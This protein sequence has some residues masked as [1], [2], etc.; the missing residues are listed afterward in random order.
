M[1]N[2]SP[3][4]PS[5]LHQ[6]ELMQRCLLGKQGSDEETLLSAATMQLLPAQHY[7]GRADEGLLPSGQGTLWCSHP[8]CVLSWHKQT[9]DKYRKR[10]LT[11]CLQM[12]E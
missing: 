6:G 5:F 10:S 2:N 12:C 9:R 11:L 7:T 1:N 3:P 4:P 8:A